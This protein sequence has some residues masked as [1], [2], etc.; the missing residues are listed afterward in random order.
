M[1][2][3]Y[4][5]FIN[6]QK[7]LKYYK[8]IQS[9]LNKEILNNKLLLPKME[10]IFESFN[11]TPFKKMK[12]IIVGQEPYHS[13][14]MADGL[15]FST[16]SNTTPKSLSNIFKEIRSNYPNISLNGTSLKP[17]AKQGV[18]LMNTS[19]SVEQGKPNSHSKIGWDIFVKNFINYLN[20]NKDFLIFVLWGN[21]A[22]KLKP[23][24][25]AKFY[26]LESTHP[27]PLSANKGF[28]GCNHFKKINMILSSNNIKE[29]D[30]NL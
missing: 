25:D 11:K 28:L 2:K 18:L 22:K 26:I 4:I 23:F 30:W 3:E 21:S 9:F 13:K 12:V 15:A 14:D 6:S 5:N 29:I 17:W 24:I 7:E 20:E 16:Q 19:L 27:S 1:D 10:N 8:E